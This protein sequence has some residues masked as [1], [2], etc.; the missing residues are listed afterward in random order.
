MNENTISFINTIEELSVPSLLFEDKLNVLDVRNDR[1]IGEY[2]VVELSSKQ[3]DCQETYHVQIHCEI[4][5]EDDDVKYTTKIEGYVTPH[6]KTVYQKFDELVRTS[7]VVRSLIVELGKTEYK[8][9]RHVEGQRIKTIHKIQPEIR[10]TLLTH[11]SAVLLER[12]Y[13]TRAYREPLKFLQLN[14][15]TLKLEEVEYFPLPKRP[16]TIDSR[17]FLLN[18]MKKV[19]HQLPI[20]CENIYA[21]PMGHLALRTKIDAPM[22]MQISRLMDTAEPNQ[23]LTFP[24]TIPEKLEWEDDFEFLSK[25]EDIKGE[26]EHKV[27]CYLEHHPEIKEITKDF[28]QFIMTMKPDDVAK[29]ARTFFNSYSLNREKG[30]EDTTKIST[31]DSEQLC[32]VR[33]PRLTE[34]S[35]DDL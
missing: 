8:V 20:I 13:L 14:M 10:S 17:T 16:W 30:L 11:V 12:L 3:Y 31:S 7:T 27:R 26:E 25:F 1:K 9:I 35:T 2:T 33:T 34:I 28:L 24:T 5:L 29:T 32:S 23:K 4:N 21:V 19:I 15:T 6:L 18:G 22:Y